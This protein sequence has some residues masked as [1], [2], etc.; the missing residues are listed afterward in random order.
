MPPRA[1]PPRATR[2]SSGAVNDVQRMIDRRQRQQAVDLLGQHLMTYQ[3]A[4]Q[5]AG[6][7]HRGGERRAALTPIGPAPRRAA[8]RARRTA[9]CPSCSA[10]RT[11][12]DSTQVT[13]AQPSRSMRRGAIGAPPT[14]FVEAGRLAATR[15]TTLPTTP[16]T[17]QA[18]NQPPSTQQ[19]P[20]PPTTQQNPPVTPPPA[21]VKPEQPPVRP[22][23]PP[24]CDRKLTGRRRD[25]TA[26]ARSAGAGIAS[27]PHTR[28]SA[29]RRSPASGAP[30]DKQRLQS[31]D[32]G[33]RRQNSH[34][35]TLSN[36]VRSK[37]TR[38]RAT[39]QC[40]RRREITFR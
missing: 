34:I 15:P 38:D 11:R 4:P 32:E 33:F 7:A 27:Q 23:S 31:L 8:R 2:R 9:P 1:R 25:R 5:A 18:N 28:H 3:N 21:Q 20:P 10:R 19:L 36:T 17:T 22:E 40:M 6:P 24:H 35:V 16:V 12:R 14:E 37:T 30:S 13:A 29:P 26:A 39:A